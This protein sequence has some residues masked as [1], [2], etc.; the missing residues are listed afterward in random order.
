MAMRAFLAGGLL[1]LASA[2]LLWA[3][4]TPTVSYVATA[5]LHV[6]V[7]LVWTVLLGWALIRWRVT[8]SPWL[9]WPAVLAWTV[10][11]IAAAILIA[12]GALTSQRPV[13][14]A[15]VLAAMAGS[16]LLL[17]ATRR[18]TAGRTGRTAWAAAGVL[19]VIGGASCRERVSDTV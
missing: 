19:L 5:L 16:A 1:L 10:S 6:G 13:L 12:R 2:A 11:T 15:H 18:F 3:L 17:A 14:I 8:V 9:W 4:D 7:G